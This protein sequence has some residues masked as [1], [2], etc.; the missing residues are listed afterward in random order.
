SSLLLAGNNTYTGRISVGP[1]AQVRAVEGTG[2]DGLGAAPVT[3]SGGTL[4]ISPVITAAGGTAGFQGRYYIGSAAN[5]TASITNGVIGGYDFGLTPTPGATRVD[6]T[7][8]FSDFTQ[9][10]Q[11]PTGLN[12]TGNANFGILWTRIL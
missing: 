6:T 8:N 10:A 11:R 1:N 12:P 2:V 3:L 7:I 9:A 5:T 4:G